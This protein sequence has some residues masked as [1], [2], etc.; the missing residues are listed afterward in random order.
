MGE[1]KQWGRLE[2]IKTE[3]ELDDMPRKQ[4]KAGLDRMD[5][6]GAGQDMEIYGTMN[7]LNLVCLVAFASDPA[8]LEAV[9]AQAL[10]LVRL[11]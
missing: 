2:E 5:T 3:G 1:Y 7:I 4:L 9:K 6:G 11:P 8:L 10:K